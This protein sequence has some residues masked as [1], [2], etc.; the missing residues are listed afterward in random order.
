MQP[1][2]RNES[3]LP[4]GIRKVTWE[5]V[6]DPASVWPEGFRPS[7]TECPLTEKKCER[8]CGD[9]CRDYLDQREAL[10]A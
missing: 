7:A 4:L 8:G 9:R 5:E 3:R 1:E 2:Q 10:G 6:N